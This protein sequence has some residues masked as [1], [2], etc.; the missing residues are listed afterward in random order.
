MAPLNTLVRF[1]ISLAMVIAY[2]TSGCRP[3]PPGPA[4][5]FVTKPAPLAKTHLRQIK[6]TTHGKARLQDRPD[7][8]RRLRP[9]RIAGAAVRPRR[10]SRRAG[11]TRNRKAWRPL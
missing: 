9:Q 6:E 5:I 1:L 4:A 10:H 3:N 11:R 7:C 2:R 8:W